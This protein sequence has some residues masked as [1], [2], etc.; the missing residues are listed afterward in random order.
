MSVKFHQFYTEVALWNIDTVI[1]F[2]KRYLKAVQQSC[3]QKEKANKYYSMIVS[4][5]SLTVGYML[6]I[7]SNSTKTACESVAVYEEVCA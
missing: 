1:L 2:G 6:Y 3:V 4:E 7:A 5:C